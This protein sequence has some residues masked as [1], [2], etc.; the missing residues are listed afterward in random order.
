MNA[1]LALMLIMSF[2]IKFMQILILLYFV[3][4]FNV[5]YSESLHFYSCKLTILTSL[6][7]FQGLQSKNNFFIVFNFEP[8][9]V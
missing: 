4:A 3:P 5:F 2:I 9:S 6:L 1:L 7:L 8:F